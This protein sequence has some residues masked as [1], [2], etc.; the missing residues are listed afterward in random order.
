MRQRLDCLTRDYLHFRAFSLPGTWPMQNCKNVFEESCG[1]YTLSW[2]APTNKRLNGNLFRRFRS[3]SVRSIAPNIYIGMKDKSKSQGSTYYNML[4]NRAFYFG[5]FFWKCIWCQQ[6]TRW[7]NDQAQS[8]L[9]LPMCKMPSQ[10]FAK[11]LYFPNA[12]MSNFV[13]YL[14]IMASGEKSSL[15]VKSNS[16]GHIK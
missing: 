5:R 8:L 16:I 15:L 4:A 12:I 14:F 3:K 1:H 2:T 6:S 13:V 10:C 11:K 9:L 7:P